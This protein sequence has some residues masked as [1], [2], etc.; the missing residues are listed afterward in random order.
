MAAL[1]FSVAAF[2]QST[3]YPQFGAQVF[4]EPGQSREEIRGF[5]RTLKDNNMDFA[6]IR[7][8]GSHI[9]KD[10]GKTDFTLYDYAFDAAQENGIRLFVTL[11][12]KTDELNDVGGFKFPHSRRH[13]K[14]VDK[15]IKAVVE[16]FCEHPALYTWVLQNEPGG[17]NSLQDNDLSRS[18][19][20]KWEKAH[21]KYSRPE[22]CLEADFSEEQFLRYYGAWYLG[23]IAGMI[24][25]YDRSGHFK[26]VNPHAL[27]DNLQEY[28][29]RRMEDILTSLGVS[30]HMSWHFGLFAQDDLT[31]GVAL[32]CDI[33]RQRAGRNPFWVT[34][35]Q[36][37]N[38]TA[39]G[40]VPICP[41]GW[42]V[43]QWLWTCVGSGCEGVI[44]WTLNPRMAVME[45]GEWA[46]VDYQGEASER[47]E[48]AAET[49]GVI[50]DHEELFSGAV[51]VFS[52]Y[53]IL[54][55][56]ESMIIQKRNASPSGKEYPGRSKSAVI[57]SVIG[58]YE[59]LQS[60]GVNPYVSNMDDFDWD[61]ARH[62]VSIIP[63]SVCISSSLTDRIKNYVRNGG[64]V[65]MTGL[66]GF[67]DEK[68]KCTFIGDQPLS[69]VAGAELAEFKVHQNYFDI[70]VLDVCLR[71][72]LWKGI[73]K[74]RNASTLCKME[75]EAIACVNEYGMG[76]FIWL[77]TPVEL[78]ASPESL[79]RFYLECTPETALDYTGR[80]DYCDSH[81]SSRIL[82]TEEA[83]IYIV[84]NT[85]DTAKDVRIPQGTTGGVKTI[86]GQNHIEN[87]NLTVKAH[88]TA[89]V[90]VMKRSQ[91]P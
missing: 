58:A 23:H 24:D 3:G 59:G 18:V 78:A 14:E 62:P 26:H 82:E 87:G 53:S 29:F 9:F 91:E 12:P 33:I 11:F 2:A 81:L 89:V 63:N 38:V 31:D 40:Y 37:G 74:P 47:L 69:E 20:R 49:A 56:D 10:N 16:H 88:G 34:E 28:D 84:T 51:P 67:Y 44:F 68:M 70:N 17:V 27:M 60:N 65:I 21:G 1:V 80:L 6:R 35:L 57:R 42:Q 15:Y 45:A 4:I 61:P 64:T 86:F 83:L 8:F 39:S 54:Y 75:G 19:R 73:L 85:A 52:P 71:T 41:T 76:R 77:P 72:H 66:S 30:M 13:L 50:K 43:S 55:N 5:F 22:S 48:A 25:R 90:M 79:G 7:L 46:L 36:G 32:M